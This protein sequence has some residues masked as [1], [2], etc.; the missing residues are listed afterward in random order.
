MDTSVTYA[1]LELRGPIVAG[2]SPLT[3]DID[4]ARRLEEAG[5][6]A[7]VMHSL[8][9]EQIERD[10]LALHYHVEATAHSHP[11]ADSYL[12]D[13]GG[14]RLGPDA[15]VEQLGRL[16]RAV[17]I[18]VFGSLNGI[19]AGGWIR[20]A[21]HMEQAGADAI[22]LNLYDVPTDPDESGAEVE[23][24]YVDTVR[25]V[26]DAVSIPVA[27]KL[28]PFLSAPVHMAARLADAGAAA[29]VVFNRFY[30][31]DIDIE[32]LD[33]TPALTLSSPDEL[34]LRLRWL[35]AM[36]GRV[37]ASLAATGGVHSAAGAIKALMAGASAVQM[38]SAILRAGPAAVAAVVAEMLAWLEE[39][40]Y[41]SV[42]QMIGS[43]SLQRC[44]DPEAF[45]RAN[46]M[47]VLQ[48]WKHGGVV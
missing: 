4:T 15:Y 47:Q 3:H 41:E 20:Y 31:P 12:P 38:T 33:V 40:E 22:E 9:E 48:S 8:F 24:R 42:R 34:R 32:A 30:Q 25:A 35:A 16:K 37:S 19:S 23:A 39:H 43:M 18:P 7:I 2:A 1:G 13:V 5:A 6:A 28:S 45:E 44:P 27:V 29:I 11:E 46:Y 17:S 26:V 36:Y 14:Y 21:A 10:E